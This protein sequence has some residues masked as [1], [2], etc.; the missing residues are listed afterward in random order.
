M[1]MFARVILIALC[2]ATTT[3]AHV[4]I[5]AYPTGP[6]RLVVGFAPGGGSDVLARIIAQKLTETMGHTW[7]VDNRPGA[8]GNLSTDIVARANPDGHTVLIAL[9][10]QLTAN[11]VIYKVSFRVDKDFQP[12]TTVASSDQM[13][14]VH[15]SMPASTLKDFIALAKQKPGAFSYASAGVGTVDHLG[16]ELLNRRTGI[17]T[18]HIPYK[19]GAPA[20]ASVLAGETHMRIGSV[21]STIPYVAAGR[22][23][24]LAIA[25]G[26]RSKLAPEIPTI[27]E[28][29]YPD[30]AIDVWYAL[31]VPNATPRSSID[32]L[33]SHVHK[34][35]EY[36]DVQTAME[37]G[38]LNPVAS[39]SAELA[40]R[41]RKE[42][43]TLSSVIKEA[44]IR[45]D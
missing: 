24:A 20:S 27:A 41:I 33:R 40:A 32:Q 43:E 26:K 28:S 7:V 14:V 8:G 12:V 17:N 25:S 42:A 34:A 22:L 45:A 39:S 19:G 18:V 9:N 1:T 23:R 5:A 13:L 11:P 2:I 15:P 38:G 29:G 4:A 37:R 3:K 16:I 35:L 21:A 31:M 6:I 30:L 10:T 36:P 44:G